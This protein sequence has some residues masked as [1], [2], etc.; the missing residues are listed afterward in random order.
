M[1]TTP[2]EVLADG[3]SLVIF[4]E[5]TRSRDYPMPPLRRSG[6]TSLMADAAARLGW[7]P[8]PAP[9]AINSEPLNL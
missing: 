2:G 3:W 5:G 4:P 6:L 9:T 7:H 8:Y 1:A